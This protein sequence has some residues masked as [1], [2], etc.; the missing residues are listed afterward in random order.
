MQLA[1]RGPY[2]SA[3]PPFIAELSV[4]LEAEVATEAAEASM[5]LVRFDAEISR[6][7]GGDAAEVSPLSAVLL[8]TESASSSQIEQITAGARALALATLGESTGPNAALVAANAQAMRRAIALSDGITAAGIIEVQEVLLHDSASEHAGAFRGGPVW[9][10]GRGSTPHT[11]TFVA[12]RAERVPE[13]I[14]DLVAFIHRTDIDPLVQTAVAHAQFETI[15]PF[16]D[17][18]GRTGRALAHAMLRQYG[19]TRRMTVPVSA[20]LLASVASYY[21]A[22]GS[23]REGD[24]NPI[25]AEF[26]EATFMACANGRILVRELEELLA[27][28]TDR[29]TARSDAA[30]WKALP[31]VISQPA[32]TVQYLSGHLGVSAPA[33]QHAVDQMV[34]A[35]ILV[36]VGNRKRNRV[37]TANDVV[38]SLDDFAQR[39][40][41]RPF[42][43]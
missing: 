38:L 23:Y 2:P 28:W 27:E 11:A 18:N 39:A 43:G 29:V 42:A 4:S 22:L 10:G 9:I 21:E 17:G 19:V 16:A 24:V 5:E 1:S 34:A 35:E 6:S 40:G 13:L 14:D 41:R 36:P 12:P 20:G 37:W 32:V 15:H 25:V 7:L 31:V 26:A 3:I 8:R 30:V 33:A